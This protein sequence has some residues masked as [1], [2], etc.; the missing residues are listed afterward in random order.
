M[1]H[2][3]AM[4]VRRDEGIAEF[5]AEQVKLQVNKIQHLMTAVMVKDEHYGTI[6]GTPKP[7]LYKAGA[8]KLSLI[9]RLAPDYEIAQTDLSGD[10]REYRVTC[11]MRH[12]TSGQIVG[13]G[14]GMCSSRES[15]Y[16]YRHGEGEDTGNPV[17]KA[18]WEKRDQSLLGGKGFSAKKNENGQWMI[19][20][21]SA[22]RVEHPDIAD[23]FNTIL[24]MAK[25]RAHVDAV[26]TAT[27]ASDIFAQDLEDMPDVG[28]VSSPP[29]KTAKPPEKEGVTSGEEGSYGSDDVDMT[30]VGRIE[31]ILRQEVIH[32]PDGTRTFVDGKRQEWFAS[33]GNEATRKAIAELIGRLVGE[34]PEQGAKLKRGRPA[35][36]KNKAPGQ[37]EIGAG[38][39][40]A[41]TGGTEPFSL[42]SCQSRMEAAVKF[43]GIDAL[44]ATWTALKTEFASQ[45]GVDEW[46]VLVAEYERL[47]N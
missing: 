38:P 40:Y 4:A 29:L 33:A 13:Q 11:T 37:Q 34:T 1:E 19:H 45:G 39:S 5:S 42:A 14:V 28:I 25:K 3:D 17:P 44:D 41:P 12:I 21:R 27:A 18:Y 10:H 22:E 47:R 7:T 24:K 23:T 36:S 15:K 8:E 35:G 30:L 43:G 31:E 16:R 9:F 2:S 32:R 46:E 6:P 26:L 20:A